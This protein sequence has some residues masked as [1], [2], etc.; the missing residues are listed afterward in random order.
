MRRH[1]VRGAPA[2]VKEERSR[3]RVYARGRGQRALPARGVGPRAERR[4]S[5]RRRAKASRHGQSARRPPDDRSIV[6]IVRGQ[7]HG[8]IRAT[9]GREVFFHRSDVAGSAFND[10]ADGDPVS[11]TLTDDTVSA[12]GDSG[13]REARLRI[14]DS[15]PAKRRDRARFHFLNPFTRSMSAS[16]FDAPSTGVI[17]PGPLPRRPA[18]PVDS[19]WS[20]E[21]G[22]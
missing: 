2:S 16:V 15:G 8:F 22:G 7:S 9:D 18:Y 21:R 6:R 19:L 11:F 17:S 3:G 20:Q 13:A 12:P 5:P 1:R 10:L 4:K 14:T